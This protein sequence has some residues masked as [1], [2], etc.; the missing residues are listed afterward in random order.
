MALTKVR[1]AGAEGLTLSSTALTVANG[2]TLTDG[3][4][5]LANGHGIDFSAT[6]DASGMSNELLDD[7]EEGTWTPSFNGYTSGFVGTYTKVGNLVTARIAR[8]A[9]IPS[10]SITGTLT[11][12]GLPFTG[13]A[14]GT[15]GSGSGQNTHQ[16]H[17]RG[18]S[19]GQS[20]APWGMINGTSMMMHNPSNFGSSS[21]YP[22][23][24]ATYNASNMPQNG[25]T[26]CILDYTFTY[27]T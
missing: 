11:I 8:W 14:N 22:G 10:S 13:G 23:Q 17:I 18:G 21:V 9:S 27:M 7:Y 15:N 26:S 19:S 12:T 3:D 24:A 2:L 25:S 6:S 5:T 1:G 4:V 16:M 20:N